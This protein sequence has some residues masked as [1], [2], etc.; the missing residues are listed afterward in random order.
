MHCMIRCYRGI[1]SVLEMMH[2][3]KALYKS[4]F[5]FTL[6]SF[7]FNVH[8]K[9]MSIQLSS[10]CIVAAPLYTVGYGGGR[11]TPQ[12]CHSATT[13]KHTGQESGVNCVK[14]TNVDRFC[15]QNL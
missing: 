5:Y 6:L 15:S 10:L 11:A 4:T 3:D 8:L 13:V 1:L 14:V 7:I 2:H 9:L 12:K